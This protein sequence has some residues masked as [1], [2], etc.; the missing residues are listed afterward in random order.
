MSDRSS[1]INQQRQIVPFSKLET[2]IKPSL[3]KGMMVRAVVRCCRFCAGRTK[4]R[5]GGVCPFG[6]RSRSRESDSPFSVRQPSEPPSLAAA[7]CPLR[8]LLLLARLPFHGTT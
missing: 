1:N 6:F 4:T 3:V 8:A 2:P 5:I 7:A